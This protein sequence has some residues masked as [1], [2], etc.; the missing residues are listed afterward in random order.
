MSMQTAEPAPETARHDSQVLNSLLRGELAAVHT[1][2]LVIPKLEGRPEAADLQRI[3]GEH[4]AS[5]EVLRER[6]RQ[7]G[8]TPAESAGAWGAFAAAVTGT[9]KV[10]GPAAALGTL[11]EG[12][13]YGIGQYENVLADPAAA[14]ADKE[15]VR[16][17][18]LPPC[19]RHLAD[20]TRLIEAV[21]K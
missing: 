13:D 17:R 14:E 4:A 1:Y 2:D 15:L 21:K 12:E 8:G 10:F 6:V 3:R 20:L 9:A 16:D 5:V 19:H 11:K 18:L 7:L